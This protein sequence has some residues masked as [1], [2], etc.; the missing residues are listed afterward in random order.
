MKKHTVGNLVVLDDSNV[1]ILNEILDILKGRSFVAVSL[2]KV[3]KTYVIHQY[4]LTT[5]QVLVAAKLL[6][7]NCVNDLIGY[8]EYE[9]D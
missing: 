9:E 2:D 3:N 8:D 6:E 4:N 7:V 5:E 1:Q